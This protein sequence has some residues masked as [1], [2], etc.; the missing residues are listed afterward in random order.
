MNKLSLLITLALL[1]A[2]G[3][4]K[5]D[6][7]TGADTTVMNVAELQITNGEQ[8]ISHP[9]VSDGFIFKTEQRIDSIEFES[10]KIYFDWQFAYCDNNFGGEPID[11]FL[12][13]FLYNSFDPL[14]FNGFSN[15]T[16][17]GI[18][19]NSLTYAKKNALLALHE[20]IGEKDFQPLLYKRMKVEEIKNNVIVVSVSNLTDVFGEGETKDFFYFDLL[21]ETELN[22]DEAESVF[23]EYREATPR[24]TEEIH[25]YFYGEL[26]R[27][28]VKA[29]ELEVSWG[30][31]HE[32]DDPGDE[33]SSTKEIKGKFEKPEKQKPEHFDCLYTT[34]IEGSDYRER[35]KL[36][37]EKWFKKHFFVNFD[38][39][40]PYEHFWTSCEGLTKP[41]HIIIRGK[42]IQQLYQHQ[43]DEG[44][45][46]CGDYADKIDFRLAPNLETVSCPNAHALWYDSNHNPKLKF[47]VTANRMQSGNAEE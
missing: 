8:K 1:S 32:P 10:K 44:E 38:F 47:I 22:S 34:F 9:L 42:N 29:D 11:A 33:Y 13:N 17:A 18:V 39:R 45:T 15:T 3:G 20:P 46:G 21:N 4:K 26:C 5:N 31:Y 27:F 2:C 35:W 40:S 23:A 43:Y 41:F 16:V 12:T 6:G 36:W 14:F 7:K 37:Y 28:C 25:I 30:T 24:Y 19:N